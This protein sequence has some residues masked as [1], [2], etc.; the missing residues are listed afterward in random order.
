MYR[1]IVDRR[2]GELLI[3]L[4]CEE[5]PARMQKTAL[6][7]LNML[8]SES[9]QA[10]RLA[11]FESSILMVTP[12]RLVYAVRIAESSSNNTV[13]GPPVSIGE[14]SK[15]GWLRKF[16]LSEAETFTVEE[17]G[18]TKFA[19]WVPG[20]PAATIVSEILPT[21]LAKFPWP[22]SMRWGDG[23]ERWVR[24]LQSILCLFDGDVV[25]FT[26]AA[27]K[28]GRTTRGHRFMAPSA[29]DVRDFA[30]YRMQLDAARV[31]LDAGDRRAV[32]KAKA[33]EL[34]E[35]AG[36]RLRPD[37]ALLDEIAGLVEWPVP[38]LGRIDQ[39]F[40]TIPPEVLVSTMRANQ[41]YLTLEDG[42]G[43]LAPYFITVANIEAPDD[44]AAIIAGNERV[45]RARL[46]DAKFFW[47]QDRKTALE[48][49]LPKLDAMVFHAELGTMREKVE[50]LETLA[51]AI[52]DKTGADRLAVERAARLAKAD[53]VSGMVG[54]FPE[55]QGIMG[56]HYARAQG[57]PEAI[58]LAIAE[59]YRPLGPADA[60]PTAPVAVA[61]ALADKLD[62]LTGFFAAG[63]RP[64][65]SKDPFALRRAALGVIRLVTENGLRL[66]LQPLFAVALGAHGQRFAAVDPASLAR[67]LGS[68]FIDRLKVQ[69][70]ERGVRHD[71]IEAVIA[72]RADGDLVRVLALVGALQAFLATVDG[73]NLL[74]AYRRAANI[75]RIEEKKDGTTFAGAVDPA[76]LVEPAEAALVEK[77]AA[78]REAVRRHLAAEAF[79]EAMAALA[80]L[81]PAVDSFFDAVL[82]NVEDSGLRRNRL[83]I[84][85]LLRDDV[86]AIADFAAIEDAAP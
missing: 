43:Q 66:D 37:P 11:V 54:E 63:I 67:E 48:A 50:R 39:E 17:K 5:I 71:L 58:A 2:S 36:C 45:L 26:F 7:Q 8:F 75:V 53:L 73:A 82:V 65:G 20:R 18:V 25:P 16:G 57:E 80:A 70:R 12:R 61:V 9:L 52:A 34:A 68:F 42:A 4:L 32:I 3:E 83:R 84:L 33:T 59:H 85:T 31:M 62:T 49:F 28:S 6:D 81:R 76:L 56:G 64:T 69:A 47:D 30:D 74:A 27:V 46:W 35:G 23:E 55:V 41:K 21:I 78:T 15:K 29:I 1:D 24:P 22:K 60:C 40:M 10:E 13:V 38:L 77:L 14:K 19:V 44:G 51:V 86:D 72:R 79:G